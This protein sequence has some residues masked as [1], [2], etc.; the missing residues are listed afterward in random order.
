MVSDP[1]LTITDVFMASLR[2]LKVINVLAS[3]FCQ[4]P[5]YLSMFHFD[6]FEGEKFME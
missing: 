2:L 3:W 1:S 4:T 5:F 6:N